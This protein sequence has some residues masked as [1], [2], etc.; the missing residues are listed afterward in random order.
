[1][2]PFACRDEVGW[3]LCCLARGTSLSGPLTVLNP[4]VGVPSFVG[5]AAECYM[6]HCY[7]P[8]DPDEP[9]RMD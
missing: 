8:G 6:E 3:V 9:A 4:R 5:V 2:F 7:E 1:V